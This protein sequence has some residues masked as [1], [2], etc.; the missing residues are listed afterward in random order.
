MKLMYNVFNYIKSC[1]TD[2]GGGAGHTVHI[3]GM[4][5]VTI[6]INIFQGIWL[7]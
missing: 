4:I 1:D 7:E 5:L 3:T 6:Q 2:N